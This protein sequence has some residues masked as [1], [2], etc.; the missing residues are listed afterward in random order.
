MVA[1]VPVEDMGVAGV[2]DL[3]TIT[4]EDT[5]LICPAAIM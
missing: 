1:G 2:L 4:A 5:L 3:E